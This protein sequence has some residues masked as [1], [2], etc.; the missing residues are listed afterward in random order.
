MVPPEKRL[1]RSRSNR[2]IAGVCGGV[3]EFFGLDATLVRLAFVL[4][5]FIGFGFLLIVYLA[6]LFIVPEEP[7]SPEPV[8]PPVEPPPAE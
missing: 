6:M 2:M 1:Y 7:L 3:A 5:F 8:P 4:G